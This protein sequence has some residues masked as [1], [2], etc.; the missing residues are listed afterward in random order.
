MLPKLK[1]MAKTDEERKEDMPFMVAE[2]G[3]EAIYPHGLCLY[4]DDATLEK[5][6]LDGECEPGDFIHVFAMAKVTSV[7]KN[8][9]GKGEKTR[10]E[11]QITHMGVEDEGEEDE[12]E[13]PKMRPRS[14]YKE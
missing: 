12:K 11:L 14:R 3:N 10:I 4:L 7:S 5:L 6:D 9:T 1:D 13:K 2:I 8:D